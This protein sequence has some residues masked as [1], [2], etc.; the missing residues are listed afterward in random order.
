MDR[1][2]ALDVL[3]AF[4]ALEAF[5]TAVAA[6]GAITPTK[7]ILHAED[8]VH[9]LVLALQLDVD[10]EG[11]F[12]LEKVLPEHRPTMF[13]Q[14]VAASVPLMKAEPAMSF[15]DVALQSTSVVDTVLPEH[16]PVM[17]LQMQ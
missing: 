14:H 7:S 10:S 5:E 17:F 8:A 4:D 3:D 15:C 6:P 13:T 12:W 1:P 16:R 11:A 9:A 2:V